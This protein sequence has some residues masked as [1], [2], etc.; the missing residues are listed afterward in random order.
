MSNNITKRLTNLGMMSA[1]ALILAVF[2]H[3]PLVPSVAFLAC[4]PK[5]V[6]IAIAGFIYGPMS[7]FLV[8]CIVSVLELFFTGGNIFDVIMNVISTCA[9]A[10]TAAY[11]YK[12]N[13]TK[14]TAILGLVIGILC[15]TASMGFWNYIVD[16]IYYNMSRQ[17]VLVSFIPGVLLF[18]ILKG[19]LN[20]GF[21]IVLYKPIVQALRK[22]HL[23]DFR[24]GHESHQQ[25]AY[26]VGLF[27]LLTTILV[28]CAF[29]NI[30]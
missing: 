10:C 6:V 23:V 11:I 5:D 18:N 7:S 25:P 16:P 28:I 22:S 27:T 21:T 3:I 9:F 24:D 13:R 14:N 8:S 17:V 2:V 19:A 12:R 26:I 1:V 15:S 30:I 4:E 20:T 29:N